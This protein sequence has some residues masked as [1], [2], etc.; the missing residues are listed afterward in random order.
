MENVRDQ[1]MKKKGGIETK[2]Q[3]LKEGCEFLRGTRGLRA[4]LGN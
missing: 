4:P 3:G 2:E 1:K